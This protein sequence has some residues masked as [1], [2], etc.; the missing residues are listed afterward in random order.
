MPLEIRQLIR[1]MS[2]ANPVPIANVIGW[3]VTSTRVILSPDVGCLQTA[4]VAVP[5]VVPI[6]GLTHGTCAVLFRCI[7][8][9]I[10]GGSGSSLGDVTRVPSRPLAPYS[11][12]RSL[13]LPIRA[14]LI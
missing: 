7:N 14:D 12:A 11:A 2:L 8:F 4:V 6:A 5:R 9:K 13:A 10:K 1:E 3:P